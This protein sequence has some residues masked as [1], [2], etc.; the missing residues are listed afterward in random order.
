MDRKAKA[1]MLNMCMI[2]DETTNRVLVQDKIHDKWGGITFPGGHVEKNESILN[3]AIR[4]VKEETG[5]TVTD[6]KSCG[7]IDWYDA[8]QNER[9]LIFLYKTKTFSGDLIDETAE[10]KV[11]WTD[12]DHL[13]SLNLSP[14]LNDFLKVFLNEDLNEAFAEYD[15]IS[16]ITE[17][18]KLI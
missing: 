17:E 14:D 11:F 4:E 7:L 16:G 15:A 1:L 18:L 10:G 8:G 2:T 5:L 12:L 3:S 6:L 13:H 9:W